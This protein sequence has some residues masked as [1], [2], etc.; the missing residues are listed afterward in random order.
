MK[1]FIILGFVLV[2]FVAKAQESEKVSVEKKLYGAYFGLLSSGFQYETRL[3]RKLTLMSELGLILGM[4][5]RE[6]DNPE[7][8]DQTTTIFAPYISVESRCYYGLDRR[9][10]LGRNIK[11]NSSNYFSLFTS[12]F[13]TKTPVIKN[14]DFDITPAI[15]LV[16]KYGIRRSFAK[17]FNYEFS[18]GYGL[19]YNIFSKSSVYNCS[20]FTTTLDLQA[21]IGYNF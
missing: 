1:N 4:S 14:G 20:H 19:Q 9:N 11:N 18:G 16:P 6:F 2:S 5:T 17:N 10:R 8:K 12:Y 15:F 7:I 13:S 3:D 21:R